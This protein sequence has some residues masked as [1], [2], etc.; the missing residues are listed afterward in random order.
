MFAKLVCEP[1]RENN[2]LP[3]LSCSDSEIKGQVG[4]RG[5][6][7]IRLSELGDSDRVK[8]IGQAQLF[9]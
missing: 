4:L 2:Y 7:K 1:G 9:I 3:E 6:R 5:R 8:E